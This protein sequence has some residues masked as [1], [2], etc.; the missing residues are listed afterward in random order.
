MYWICKSGSSVSYE[1]EVC[2]NCVIKALRHFKANHPQCV[3]LRYLSINSARNNFYSIPPLIKYNID[4]IA[5]VK[6]KVDPSF[7]ES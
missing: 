3:S 7:P 6:T 4:K 5:T 1:P 2:D